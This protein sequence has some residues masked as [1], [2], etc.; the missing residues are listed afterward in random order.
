MGEGTIYSVSHFPG[1][2]FRLWNLF[3][4]QAIYNKGV[5]RGMN[6]T[7]SDLPLDIQLTSILALQIDGYGMSEACNILKHIQDPYIVSR[8]CSVMLSIGVSE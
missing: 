7:V 6:N 1:S 2:L 3:M 5:D 4:L 8:A